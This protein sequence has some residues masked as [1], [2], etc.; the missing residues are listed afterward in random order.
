MA[1]VATSERQQERRTP[2]PFRTEIQKLHAWMRRYQ[3]MW[4]HLRIAGL[5]TLVKSKWVNL[6]TS[7][8]LTDSP[9][10]NTPVPGVHRAG[11]LTVFEDL[12][13]VGELSTILRAVRN[14]RLPEKYVR[15]LGAPLIVQAPLGKRYGPPS[16]SEHH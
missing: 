10:S 3:P 13:P 11:G 6:C 15:P 7:V 12:H 4:S 8:V 14:G 1:T 2:D 5:A 9:P 16:S